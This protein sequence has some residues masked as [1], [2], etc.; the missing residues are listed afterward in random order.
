ME[1]LQYNISEQVDPAVDLGLIAPGLPPIVTLGQ[2]CDQKPTTP[3]LIIGGILHQGCKMIL[4]GTSKSNKTWCLLDLA[5]SVASGADWWG[6]K[7]TQGDVLYINF[8]LHDWSIHQRLLSLA[9]A[10]PD[11]GSSVMT[12]LF[13]WNLRGHNTDITMLRPDLME[14]ITAGRFSLVIIDP[15][16]KV[17]GN[18]DENA[19]GEIA[20][21]MNEF[22]AIAKQSRA[23]VVLA[24]HFAKGDSS[25]KQAGDRMSGAGAWTRDPDAILILTPHEEED[26]FTVT[27]IIRNLPKLDEF[28]VR[29]THPTLTP[30]DTLNPAALRRP[31]TK[32]KVMSDADFVSKFLTDEPQSTK[33]IC[34]AAEA[35]KLI[36]GRSASRY[37]SRLKNAKLIGYEYG[38]YYKI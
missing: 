10:R 22:E 27:S 12:R 2:L 16:Y 7:C 34:Q 21:L 24:H 14:Q 29:W 11:I 4:A 6:R 35:S 33:D 18:R 13:I 28:V 19:N 36:S 38:T 30:D 31:Q 20:S 26:C 8:E 3:P 23:A 32:N 17:L 37:L 5:C 25:S 9:H 15:A 1:I